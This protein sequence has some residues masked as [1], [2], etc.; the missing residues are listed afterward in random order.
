MRA[1][2]LLIATT[3]ATACT[4][5]PALRAPAAPV[6]PAAEDPASAPAAPPPASNPLVDCRAGYARSTDERADLAKLTRACATGQRVGEPR[7]GVQGEGDPVTRATVR[8]SAGR[9]Y[10]VFAVGG[11]GVAEVD[12]VVR[13][14]DGTLA[15]QQ[16]GPAGY[17]VAPSATTLCPTTEGAFTIELGVRRGR[18][19]FAME[20]WGT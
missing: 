8:L 6:E 1:A 19:P 18:G 13:G 15:A 14:P 12:L 4:T 10:R 5:P 11:A 20:V 3:L 16:A 7:T 17:A 2:R 9:C